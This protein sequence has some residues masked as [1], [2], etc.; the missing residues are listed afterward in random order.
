[1]GEKCYA[2]TSRSQGFSLCLCVFA[3]KN[4]PAL[5]VRAVLLAVLL[6]AVATLHAQ[7]TISLR[8][9]FRQM[10][11]TI[12]PYLT[13]TNRL[14]LIDF[15]D[16]G[17]QAEVANALSGHT[18]M[19]ALTADSLTLQLSQGSRLDILVLPTAGQPIDS[20]RQV[21]AVV[22]TFGAEE[23]QHESSITLYSAKWRKL[24]H[25]VPLTAAAEQRLEPYRRL[26]MLK[27]YDKVINKH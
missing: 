2:K 5:T 10:P 11:D 16:A 8:D 26:T 3:Y 18:T 7:D 9:A 21:M 20:C 22:L 24:H 17:M 6:T 25:Q 13:K 14:D 12:V 27:W 4:S 15:L 19:T 1:M 23:E